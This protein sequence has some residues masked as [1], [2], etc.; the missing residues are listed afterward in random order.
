MVRR[1]LAACVGLPK[2]NDWASDRKHFTQT[3]VVRHQFRWLA[4]V[5]SVLKNA[6]TN[7]RLEKPLNDVVVISR[8]CALVLRSDHLTGDIIRLL[9]ILGKNVR[10]RSNVARRLREWGTDV[11]L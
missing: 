11:N 2:H 10:I 9:E 1:E 8:F 5:P 7:A 6:H 4:V 3:K